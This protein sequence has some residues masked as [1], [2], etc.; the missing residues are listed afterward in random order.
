MNT[1]DKYFEISFKN[2]GSRQTILMIG[3]QKEL[4]NH[5]NNEYN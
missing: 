4:N 3:Q 2:N 5:N 1:V